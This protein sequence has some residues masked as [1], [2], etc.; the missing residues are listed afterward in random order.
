MKIERFFHMRTGSPFGGA[1]VRV[2]GDTDHVGQVEVQYTICSKKDLF[3]KKLGRKFAGEAPIK[4]VPLRFLSR[5][6]VSVEHR[7][8][9]LQDSWYR[10]NSAIGLDI[11]R[12]YNFAIRYFLPKE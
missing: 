2:I 11:V 7:M 4:I 8:L 3:N 12:D 6:L 5:E 1:T 10:K 9:C